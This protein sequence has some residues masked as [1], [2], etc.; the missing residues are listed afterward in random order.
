MLND[1]GCLLQS[2]S[3]KRRMTVRLENTLPLMSACKGSTHHILQQLTF[4][5]NQ[6]THFH[7]NQGQKVFF[8]W[9]NLDGRQISRPLDINNDRLN[10]LLVSQQNRLLK[11]QVLLD[12]F[13]D[14]KQTYYFPCLVLLSIYF[15]LHYSLAFIIHYLL[16]AHH[17][18]FTTLATVQLPTCLSY[19]ILAV[20][21]FK[22]LCKA[23]CERKSL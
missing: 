13:Q 16:P 21:S 11:T 10:V 22:A 7:I 12:T 2:K 8:T 15:S 17:L 20:C 19:N 14:S 3:P 9:I 5:A 18:L 4:L 1:L 23:V 6:I